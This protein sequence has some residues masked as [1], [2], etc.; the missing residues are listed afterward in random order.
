M[1]ELIR[2]AEANYYVYCKKKIGVPVEGFYKDVYDDICNGTLVN[3]T[4]FN[5][6]ET[7]ISEYKIN[8]EHDENDNTILASSTGYTSIG[9][10]LGEAVYKFVAEHCKEE[11]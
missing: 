5:R 6:V 3:N 7:F 8:I 2:Q 1:K 11:L 9:N 10:S 4:S